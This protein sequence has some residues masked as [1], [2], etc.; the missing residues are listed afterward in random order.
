METNQL[1]MEATIMAQ[2][3]HPHIAYLVGVTTAD[4]PLLMHMAYYEHGASGGPLNKTE[5]GRVHTPPP[6]CFYFLHPV[7][8]T[9][10][11]SCSLHL[12]LR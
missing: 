7:L 9:C 6:P 8:L 12:K 1:L 2:L 11:C 4:R 10:S 5:E 3:D